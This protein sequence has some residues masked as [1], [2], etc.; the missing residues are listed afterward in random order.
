[1]KRS[2]FHGQLSF[3]KGGLAFADR[4][5][6]V[7]P[8]YAREIQTRPYG[9]GLD[10]LLRHR[11]A[12]LSGILNGIDIKEWDPAHDPYQVRPYSARRL[13]AKNANKLALQKE[14][15]LPVDA[16]IPLIGM[17]GRL[18]EQ[19]GIDLVLDILPR[20]ARLRPQLVILGSGETRYEQALRARGGAPYRLAGGAP[21]L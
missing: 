12:A 17:V 5:T 13:A 7:S 2:E 6:T 16:T 18:V 19:K 4:L 8:T 20:L 10:G 9:C 1:M 11:A 3:I 14:S 21:R 15:G